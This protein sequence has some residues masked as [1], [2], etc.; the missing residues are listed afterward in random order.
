MESTVTATR[1]RAV[2]QI[3]A[4]HAANGGDWAAAVRDAPA[5]S[6]D[7]AAAQVHVTWKS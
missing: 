1:A 7:G 5:M 4:N 2:V 3:L 6:I